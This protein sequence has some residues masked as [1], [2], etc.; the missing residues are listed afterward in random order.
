M[1]KLRV[2]LDSTVF[3]GLSD[4]RLAPYSRRLLDRV[5]EGRYTAIA[6]SKT[7]LEL[8]R[9]SVDLSNAG[10]ERAPASEEVAR[11]RDAYLDAHVAS[12]EASA[13]AEH[14]AQATVCQADVLVSWNF[15]NIVHFDKIR[16]F[17]AV[18]MM[19]RYRPLDIYSPRV[20]VGDEG[21][22]DD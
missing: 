16:G 13:D 5:R 22:G 18:N 6:S 9:S 19:N 10:F 11:L 15:K 2:Y 14:V 12:A 20:L 4:E 1:K 3:R 8:E 17:S 7:L 21:D